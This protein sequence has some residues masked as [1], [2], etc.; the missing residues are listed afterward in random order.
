M[1][2]QPVWGSRRGS[3][4]LGLRRLAPLVA[5]VAAAGCYTYQPLAAAPEPGT[6]VGL[7]LNDRGRVELTRIVG[8]EVM[9]VDGTVLD[10]N[11]TAYRLA[12]IES[13]GLR[14]ARSRWSGEMVDFRRD[15]VQALARRQFSRPRTLLAVLAGTAAI[16]AFI[17]SRELFGLGGEGTT[18]V[19]PWDG[20]NEQ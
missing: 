8:P 15:Y 20:G 18:G 14:G 7:T 12:V 16:S 4:A 13:V 10:V 2:A 3:P 17:F 6:P 1:A 5:L 11:D 19:P 9:R